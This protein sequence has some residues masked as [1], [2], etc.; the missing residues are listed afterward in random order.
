MSFY[1]YKVFLAVDG[2]NGRMGPPSIPELMRICM[3]TT[4]N[5]ERGFLFD[6][7]VE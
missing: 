5:I 3:V 1:I 4:T 6:S 7:T 2:R